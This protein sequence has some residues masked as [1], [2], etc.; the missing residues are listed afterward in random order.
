MADGAESKLQGGGAKGGGARGEHLTLKV[1]GQD[2][3]E[4]FFK[5][6]RAA[7]LKKLMNAYCERQNVSFGQIRFLYDCVRLQP[8]NTPVSMEMED[9]DAVDAMLNMQGG[10][11]E[12]AVQLRCAGG[13]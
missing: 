8:E 2:G 3:H 1:I 11:M 13:A 4:V 10:A 12:I 6:R 9:G 5:M 7:P